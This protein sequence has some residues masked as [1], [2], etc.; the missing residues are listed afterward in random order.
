MSHQRTSFYHLGVWRRGDLSPFLFII[1]ME[2]LNSMLKT[3]NMRGWIRGFKVSSNEECSLEIT[4]PLNA[5]DFWFSVM[6]SLNSLS[7]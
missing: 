2:R 6:L 7:I 1:V 4:H 3:A 5:N